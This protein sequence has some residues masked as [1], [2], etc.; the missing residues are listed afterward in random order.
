MRKLVSALMVAACLTAVAFG[1]QKGWASWDKKEVDKMLNN[2]PWGQTQAET[3]TS[4]MTVTF[5]LNRQPDAANNQAFTFNYRIRFFSAKP[6]REA[7]AR[8][9]ILQQ[10]SITPAQL[11]NF[12]NGDY[13]EIIVVAVTTDGADHRYLNPIGTIFRG[14]T[15]STLK[16]KAY[17]ERRDGTKVYIEDYSPPSADGS[18]AKFVF[19]R[20]LDGK[21]FAAGSDETLRFVADLGR[22]VKM[23]W[24]FKLSEMSYNGVIEY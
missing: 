19:P 15:P 3:D 23:N 10:P 5:G 17:L 24:K 1:Q 20:M 21:P 16:N 8:G 7:F 11:Q 6:I 2:S 12:I 4:E 18:G 9:V 14:A 13:S 22:G